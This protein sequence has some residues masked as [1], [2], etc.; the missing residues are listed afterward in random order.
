MVPAL[1]STCRAASFLAIC[2]GDGQVRTERGFLLL[3]AP[4][5]VSENSSSCHACECS[6][7]NLPSG[8][9]L[10]SEG[11]GLEERDDATHPASRSSKQIRMC[12]GSSQVN[13]VL[14]DAINEHPIGLDMTIAKALPVSREGMIPM[15]G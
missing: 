2:L 15:P 10:S 8:S 4:D 9:I 3:P 14:V 1:M 11:S 12:A 6:R 5:L 13:N 7:V